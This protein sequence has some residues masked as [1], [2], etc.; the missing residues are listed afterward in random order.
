MRKVLLF[1]CLATLLH[2]I[3]SRDV[4]LIPIKMAGFGDFV[5]STHLRFKLKRAF[6][7]VTKAIGS[8]AQA[9]V[10]EISKGAKSIEGASA[11]G[12]K[13]TG[14]AVEVA[15]KQTIKTTET[16]LKQTYDLTKDISKKSL[17]KELDKLQATPA[18]LIFEQIAKG[19]KTGELPN[20]KNVAAD[21]KNAYVEALKAKI[22]EAVGKEAA[23][24]TFAGT[25]NPVLATGAGIAA[26]AATYKGLEEV[27]KKVSKN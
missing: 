22:A 26:E 24:L 23:V 25:A 1:L 11:K 7:G 27:Q 9:G 15:G 5:F 21:V 4:S 13:Q 10:R 3:C 8:T 19:I 16:L 17:K 6:N 12:L 20:L 14:K 2:S 18:G